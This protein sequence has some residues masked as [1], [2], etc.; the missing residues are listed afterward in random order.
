MVLV[1]DVQATKGAADRPEPGRPGKAGAK[2]HVLSHAPGLPLAAAVSAA[3]TGDSAA[4]RPLVRG[5]PVIN[6]S[7]RRGRRWAS[8]P[9]SQKPAPCCRSHRLRRR[10]YSLAPR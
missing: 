6:S 8:L 9:S 5:I 4:L 10:S 3:N 7:A 2:I 1:C